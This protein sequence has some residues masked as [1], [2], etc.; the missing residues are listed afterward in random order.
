MYCI[1]MS[2]TEFDHY[3]PEDALKYPF[4]TEAEDLPVEIA[5]I[6]KLQEQLIE[7]ENDETLLFQKAE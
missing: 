3:I 5:N 2:I 7:T 4:N 1:S 6:I